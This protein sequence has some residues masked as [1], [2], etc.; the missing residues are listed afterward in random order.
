MNLDVKA[1]VRKLVAAMPDG[2][3]VTQSSLYD[4]LCDAFPRETEA[5]M[6]KQLRMWIQ[7][8][9][10]VLRS[11]EMI[12]LEH[13]E[14]WRGDAVYRKGG[15]PISRQ[16]VVKIQTSEAGGV[17]QSPTSVVAPVKPDVRQGPTY[18]A[19]DL[20]EVEEV[21]ATESTMAAA[22]RKLGMTISQMNVRRQKDSA[23]S[24]AVDR[25]RARYYQT[26]DEG[27]EVAQELI[28]KPLQTCVDCGSPRSVGSGERCRA[29]YT[30]QAEQRKNGDQSHPVPASG[31]GHHAEPAQPA[32]SIAARR[33]TSAEVYGGVMLHEEIQVRVEEMASW[34]A[35]RI[36]EFF[37]ALAKVVEIPQRPIRKAI[38]L[39]WPKD[40]E[41]ESPEGMTGLTMC[42][43]VSLLH[44]S[45]EAHEKAAVW[46]LIQYIKRIQARVEQGK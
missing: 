36:T 43:L 23:V 38:K 15:L 4:K 5:M 9:I 3:L 14:L 32:T 37:E 30:A 40:F 21:M 29:C 28:M 26:A 25:G 39:A 35:E 46:T 12:A 31:N 45:M 16:D 1:E 22:A 6:A 19:L 2:A 13:G 33:T 27:E 18:K 10:D 42:Y 34:P 41:D 17:Q 8:G 44:D 24:D 20:V 7:A 11:E